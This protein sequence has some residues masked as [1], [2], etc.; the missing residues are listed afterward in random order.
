MVTIASSVA[1]ACNFLVNVL[2]CQPKPFCD[3]NVEFDD[4]LSDF[5]EPCPRNG[6]C[7]EGKLEC[8][9]GYR[10]LG[11]SCV[12]DGDINE[13][14]KKLSRLV[15]DHV[16][17][18]YAQYLCDATGKI[19]VQEDDLWNNFDEFKL[20]EHH[21]LETSIYMHAKQRAEQTVGELLEA[22][23]NNKGIKELK[24]PELLVN[25]YKPVSCYIRHWIAEHALVLVLICAV[26]LGC[27]LILVRIR[28]RHYLSVR[29]EELYNKV[30]KAIISFLQK[31]QLNFFQMYI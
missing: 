18:A 16:C 6:V 9:S 11:K 12:E 29:A 5:C 21:G 17:E 7:H 22:R 23:V 10:K 24:C 20:M 8:A 25:R 4:S 26:L 28:R 1:L 27:T 13:L 30:C 3:S 15:Q 19:W 31:S 2:N 14:A